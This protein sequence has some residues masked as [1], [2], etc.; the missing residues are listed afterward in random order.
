MAEK[1]HKLKDD[2][3]VA[4]IALSEKMMAISYETRDK[5]SQRNL[6]KKLNEALTSVDRSDVYEK[7]ANCAK[8]NRCGSLW[9]KHCRNS[10]A[11]AANEKVQRH[12]TERKLSNDDLIHLTAPVAAV[13]FSIEGVNAALKEDSLRWKRI[14]FKS[15]FWI[16]A[17][18][19]FEL[20][21]LKFLNKA[22]GSDKKK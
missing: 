5:P 4:K 17:I 12:L 11:A 18:Y 6:L 15:S 2:S 13:P 16:E 9:C 1:F 7:I 20:V 21:N 10:A 19:E 8:G 14:R 3:A 22:D